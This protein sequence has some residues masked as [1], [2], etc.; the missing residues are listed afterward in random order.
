MMRKTIYILALI[1]VIILFPLTVNA[2]GIDVKL[3]SEEQE[4]NVTNETDSIK[5]RRFC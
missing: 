1:L 2:A 4:Y 5:L 3:T